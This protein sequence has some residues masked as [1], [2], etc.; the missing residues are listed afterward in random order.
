[1]NECW[2]TVFLYCLWYI[3]CL[4]FILNVMLFT[5][6]M[7]IFRTSSLWFPK[8]ISGSKEEK[9]KEKESE[10]EPK[11]SKNAQ[12]RAIQ[13]SPLILSFVEKN[14]IYMSRD[15]W[16]LSWL[17]CSIVNVKVFWLLLWLLFTAFGKETHDW[18]KK[19]RL[20]Y[21]SFCTLR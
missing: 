15:F 8:L 18:L 3:K 1:M 9:E 7:S 14:V 20:Q 17:C 21:R 19:G 4:W 2:L 13:P 10:K 16:L 11:M 5:V 6:Y 12:F